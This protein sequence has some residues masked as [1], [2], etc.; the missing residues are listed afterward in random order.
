M[1]PSIAMYECQTVLVDP[2]IGLYQ[3]LTLWDRVD[4]RAMVMKGYSAFPKA[5][6]L[7]CLVSYPRRVLGRGS[8]PSLGMK[9][10]YSIAPADWATYN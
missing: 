1:V 3:V 6:T 2:Y 10:V 8:Y 9:S 4:Q 7:D 5:P